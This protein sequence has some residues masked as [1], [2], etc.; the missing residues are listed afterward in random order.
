MG[1]EREW[2]GGRERDLLRELA[3]LG[4]RMSSPLPAALESGG[5]DE[6]AAGDAAPEPREREGEGDA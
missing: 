4:S 5:Q 3:E 6:I 1:D 2:R